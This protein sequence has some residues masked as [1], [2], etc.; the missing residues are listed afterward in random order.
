METFI[1]LVFIVL[2]GFCLYV[3]CTAFGFIAA[4]I[5]TS[6]AWW[7]ILGGTL[8]GCIAIILYWNF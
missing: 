4:L 6:V 8:L 3:T 7:K 1:G 5:I 2:M